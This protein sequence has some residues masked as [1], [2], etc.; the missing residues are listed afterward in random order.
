MCIAP[1]W[2]VGVFIFSS[3]VRCFSSAEK[4]NIAILQCMVIIFKLVDQSTLWS[5][6]LIKE[7]Q[8]SPFSSLHLK[9]LTI[10]YNE[11]KK[12]ELSDL[13]KD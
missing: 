8:G 13:A 2:R 12:P 6:T 9:R 3:V 4:K 10:L 11:E 5:S 1:S 7:N